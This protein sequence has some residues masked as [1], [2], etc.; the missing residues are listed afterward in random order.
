L[1]AS[2]FA[3]LGSKVKLT[4]FGED[5][6]TDEYIAWLND[7]LVTRFSNQ[8]FVRR[9][10]DSCVRYLASFDG[11]PNLFVSVRRRDDDRAIG[12]MTAYVAPHH[13]TA[14][15]GILIGD[16]SAWGTGYGQDAWDTLAEFVAAQPGMRKLTAGMLARN[17]AMRRIA[18]R[19]GMTLEAT[20]RDQEL[21]DGAPVD[22]LLFAR[23][24]G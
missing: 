12:T 14:D 2:P 11:T 3:L 13:G 16:R 20:R 6:I 15:L 18:E 17:E 24:V 9:D 19:S 8:R 23:F 10:R 7:P 4:R 21:V 5:D 22:I 1:T